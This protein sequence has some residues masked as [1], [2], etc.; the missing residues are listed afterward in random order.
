MIIPMSTK[1]KISF[2]CNSCAYMS[3]K[4][5]GCCPECNEWNTFSEQ[6]SA[7]IAQGQTRSGNIKPA[8]LKAL[9]DVPAAPLERMASGIAEW[10]RVLGG[11]LV[12]GSFTIVTGDPGIGKSTLLLQ[13]ANALAQQQRVI[14][15][16]SEES[17]E[18]VGMRARR[19]LGTSGTILFSDERNIES[20]IHTA[21][22]ERPA[23]VIIDSI[24]NCAYTAGQSA[25]GSIGQLREVSFRL[26]SL[27]KEETIAIIVTGHITKDGSMAGPKVLEHMVD[28][29]LYVQGEDR[30]NTRVLRSV[31]NRFGSINE[32]GFFAMEAHGMCEVP[33]INERLLSEVSHSPGSVLVSNIEGSRPLLL[34]LQALTIATQ[35]GHP[36]RVITGVDHKRVVLIAAILEKYLQVR[37]SAHDIFFKVGGG[38]TCSESSA[39]LGIALALLASF[40]QKPLPEKSIALGE[41]SLTGTIKPINQISLHVNEA[42]KF[43]IQRFYVH[44]TQTSSAPGASRGFSH[45]YELLE[46]FPV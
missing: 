6:V 12:P 40:F 14:Y 43:G 15:F 23:L 9:D 39:D 29:V 1:Q 45:V 44:R 24:Q 4:W 25:P 19:V 46:L 30:F 21:Q 16:S 20:I 31:K 26:M 35:F 38:F 22:T 27:A 2:T 7:P 3:F 34:E 13:I 5:L 33:N 18:Q 17:L 32:L 10:D 36:Q 8:Q 37:L 42:R 28:T 41:I 11:G